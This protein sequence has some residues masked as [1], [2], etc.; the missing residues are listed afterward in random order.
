MSSKDTELPITLN[1]SWM[2]KTDRLANQTFYDLVAANYAAKR[3]WLPETK[4][5]ICENL[6]SEIAPYLKDSD[7]VLIVG[8]GTG[9]DEQ[10]LNELCGST[11]HLK[12]YGVDLSRAM[13][14]EAKEKTK[15]HLVQSEAT[16]LPFV[17]GTLDFVY[18][19]AAAEHWDAKYLNEYLVEMKRVLRIDPTREAQALLSVRKGDG[20]IIEVDENLNTLFDSAVQGFGV[21]VVASWEFLK[22]G[23]TDL[24]R[25]PNH[26][27][28]FFSTYSEKEFED[29]IRG[30]GFRIERNW[31]SVGGTP[32]LGNNFMWSHHLLSVAEER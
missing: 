11:L 24:L 5:S 19:E 32:S 28:K 13:L 20:N 1:R 29:I 21:W 8:V 10:C 22:A 15:D 9:A 17:E 4:R 16:R 14:H 7:R 31:S 30:N 23:Q 27:T 18:C 12:T 3:A 25:P 2:T 26:M 6:T